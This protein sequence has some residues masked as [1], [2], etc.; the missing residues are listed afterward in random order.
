ML[1]EETKKMEERLKMIQEVKKKEDEAKKKT[2][3][4][5]DGNHWRS[6]NKKKGV[7][8]YSSKVLT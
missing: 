1:L 2:Q 7:T 6:S 3:L 8:G 4:F 5:K